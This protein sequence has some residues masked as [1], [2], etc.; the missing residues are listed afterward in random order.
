MKKKIVFCLVIRG[1]YPLPPLSGPTT[2]KPLF[3]GVTSLSEHIKKLNALLPE[4]NAKASK[5][6]LPPPLK[7]SDV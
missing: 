1:V 6:P 4:A 3:L 7:L 2:K 5:L